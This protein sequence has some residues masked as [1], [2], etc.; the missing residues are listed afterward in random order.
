MKK[1]CIGVVLGLALLFAQKASASPCGLCS[2]NY[3]CNWSCED[4]TGTPGLWTEDGGCWGE[5]VETTCGEFYGWSWC[6]PSL[7]AANSC[8]LPFLSTNAN[9]GPVPA[10]APGL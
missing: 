9:P 1:L 7:S 10:T 2:S 8:K 4:C 5:I 3:P 6:G